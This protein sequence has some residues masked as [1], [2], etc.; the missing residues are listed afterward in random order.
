MQLSWQYLCYLLYYTIVAKLV[1][2]SKKVLFQFAG[3]IVPIFCFYERKIGLDFYPSNWNDNKTLLIV[4]KINCLVKKYWYFHR[5]QEVSDESHYISETWE[6]F[7]ESIS[8]NVKNL[9]LNIQKKN[10]NCIE[11][12]FE[13]QKLLHPN[14]QSM[15][16]WNP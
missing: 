12:S 3:S 16:E 1:L 4:W 15:T 2:D 9:Q 10:W 11:T 7:L 8:V 6:Y 14:A 5:T 13:F